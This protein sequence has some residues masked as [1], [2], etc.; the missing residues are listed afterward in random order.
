MTCKTVALYTGQ[1]QSMASLVPLRL[2]GALEIH[3]CL[4]G[5]AIKRLIVLGRYGPD[6]MM[7]Q[8]CG[9]WCCGICAWSRSSRDSCRGR[10]GFS[11]APCTGWAALAPQH[12][13]PTGRV[14]S[15]IPAT[16]AALQLRHTIKHNLG[17]PISFWS[18]N[19]FS[20]V[21]IEQIRGRNSIR[22]FYFFIKS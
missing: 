1:T 6:G 5:T 9:T 16:R 13:P 18:C 20:L 3:A 12:P 2:L 15:G 8:G 10:G 14:H 7:W 4:T 22:I 19:M 21:F 11:S 17:T